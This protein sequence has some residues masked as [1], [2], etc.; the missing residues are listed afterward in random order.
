MTTEADAAADVFGRA[1]STY[2]TIVPFFA[3]FGRLLA[4]DARLGRGDRVLDL[5]CGRG[6]A[7]WPALA[8]VGDSGY[9]LGADLAAQMVLLTQ[10]DLDQQG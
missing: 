1:A 2:D 8:Q 10:A 6:A 9:V 5:G 3:H 7:L 4:E